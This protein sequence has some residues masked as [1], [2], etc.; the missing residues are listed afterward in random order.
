MYEG[1]SHIPLVISGPNL[2]KD[3][4]IE[5]PVQHVDL[6]QTFLEWADAEPPDPQRGNSL[7]PLIEGRGNVH[8]GYAYAENHS[9]GNCTGSFMIRKGDWKYIHVS[10]YDDLLFN[11]S[12]DPNELE[13]RI[14]DPDTA[15]V[16]EELVELLQNEVNPEIV[17]QR[18]FNQQETVL[19]GLIEDDNED[20]LYDR[21]CSRLGKGRP[22]PY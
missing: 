22:K 3:E 15:D 9:E 1:A 6:V 10:W 20:E 4:T 5:T 7:I 16:Q 19:E 17:T 13:N 8:P 12:E 11:L 2:P 18:A 21:L 14:N